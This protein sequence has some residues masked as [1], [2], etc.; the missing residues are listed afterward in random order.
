MGENICKSMTYKELLSKICK[1]VI[2]FNIKKQT[3]QF[4]KKIGKT[5]EQMFF[6]RRYTDGQQA[7]EKKLSIT[8]YQ[9]CVYI[10]VCSVVSNSLWPHGL[11][12]AR[13]LFPQN[14]PGKSTG[15]GCHFLLHGIFPTQGSNPRLL[16][17]LH[18]QVDSLHQCHLG[19]P[20]I[21]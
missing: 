5:P 7:H 14:F 12:P 19:S 6:Q 13:L 20:I 21:R 4:K 9:L 1:Q 3:T 8:N 10:C 11:Q 2:Q 15:V 18:W 16:H 17:V